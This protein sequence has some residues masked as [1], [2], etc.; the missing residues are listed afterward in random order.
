M[1][2]IH[3]LPVETC[4][5]PFC[6]SYLVLSSVLLPFTPASLVVAGHCMHTYSPPRIRNSK[7]ISQNQNLIFPIPLRHETPVV[8]I[9]HMIQLA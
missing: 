4:V 2:P 6:L 7:Y 5:R 9:E 8:R 3:S 1:A